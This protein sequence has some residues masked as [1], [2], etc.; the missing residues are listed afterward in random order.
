MN[1][2][3]VARNIGIALLSN[4]VFMFLGVIVSIVYGFDSSF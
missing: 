3:V 2:S 1:L 4:A